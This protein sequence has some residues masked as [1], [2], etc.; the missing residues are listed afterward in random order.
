MR[1]ASSPSSSQQQVITPVD[2]ERLRPDRRPHP[3]RRAVA[4]SALHDAPGARL[5]AVRTPIGGLYLCGAG[6]HPGGGITAGSGRTPR[7]RSSRRL[8]NE[9]LGAI[10][11]RDGVVAGVVLMA[12]PPRP[13]AVRLLARSRRRTRLERRFLALP[14]ADRIRDAHAFLTASRM[15]RARRD[16]EL[17]E[18]TRDRSEASASTTLRSRRT[19]CCCRGPRR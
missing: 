1:P 2:L 11:A 5:G 16:R 14:S 9:G 19:K 3:P 15:W 12:Q 4:R 13:C 10:A 18:W 6:T 17:A 8:R 7:V